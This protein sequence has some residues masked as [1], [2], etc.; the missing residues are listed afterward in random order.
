[1]RRR[2]LYSV[3]RRLGTPLKTLRGRHSYG[4][5]AREANLTIRFVDELDVTGRRVLVRVDYNVPTDSKGDITDDNRIR[6]SLPTLR[7]LVD[8]NAKVILCSHSGRPKGVP[9]PRYSLESAAARLAE[10]LACDVIHT[11]DCIGPGVRKVVSEMKEGGVILLENLRFHEGETRNDPSFASALAQWGEVYV[12]D[13]FGAA[14]RAHA[15]VDATARLFSERAAG[16]LIRDELVALD[17]L[18]KEPV[19]PFVAV[20]GGAKV[21]DKM[22]V[23]ENLLQ[24]VDT[25]IV[26]GAMAYTFLAAKGVAVGASRLEEDKVWLAKRILERAQE[27]GVTFLLPTDHVVSATAD[28]ASPVSVVEGAIPQ[29]QMGLDIGPATRN[30]YSAQVQAAGTV[31]WNGPMGLFEVGAFAS[32][33]RS[34]ARAMALCPG[35]TVVGGGDSAAAASQFGVSQAVSHV[36]TG[37]GASLEYLEGKELPGLLALNVP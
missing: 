34:L 36:S 17:K 33:T 27:K 30:R 12:N 25:F 31:F 4:T 14:H 21:S 1:M 3:L 15:S 32:G 18:L 11:D 28:G 10:L 9:D 35:Y 29:G 6:A 26:G 37:G 24:R 19:R 7:S 20:L 23:F 16:F 5:S 8:R 22:G 13:A 2:G